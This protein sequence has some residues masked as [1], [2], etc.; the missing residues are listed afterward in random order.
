M[1]SGATGG[2]FVAL[3]V[4]LLAVV[5]C[6]GPLLVVAFG[7]AALGGVATF[8]R[9]PLALVAA[10]VIA[11]AVFGIMAFVRRRNASCAVKAIVPGNSR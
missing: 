9:G 3:G 5:C 10:A 4:A 6:A 2:I 7:A 1:K 8:V 11:V